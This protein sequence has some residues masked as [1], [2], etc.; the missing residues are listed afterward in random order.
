MNEVGLAQA[1]IAFGLCHAQMSI[2]IFTCPL[3][4]GS[5][6]FPKLLK[7]FFPIQSR[8]IESGMRNVLCSFPSVTLPVLIAS[9]VLLEAMS[10]SRVSMGTEMEFSKSGSPTD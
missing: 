8:R 9:L 7:D 2:L 5:G 6:S 3:S 1:T 4:T 10:L